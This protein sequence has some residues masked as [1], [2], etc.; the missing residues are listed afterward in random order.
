MTLIPKEVALELVKWNPGSP[1][2][3]DQ[4]IS[5]SM[6]DEEIPDDIVYGAIEELIHSFPDAK[7]AARNLSRLVGKEE[8]FFPECTTT[9]GTPDVAGAP[10]TTIKRGYGR[11]RRDEYVGEEIKAVADRVGENYW[12]EAD[13]EAIADTIDEASIINAVQMTVVGIKFDDEIQRNAAYE[14]LYHNMRAFDGISLEKHGTLI[15]IMHSGYDPE[16]TKTA[17]KGLLNDVVRLESIEIGSYMESYNDNYTRPNQQERRTSGMAD[18]T[19]PPGTMDDIKRNDEDLITEKPPVKKPGEPFQDNDYDLAVKS[20]V[21]QDQAHQLRVM[22]LKN[23]ARELGIKSQAELH[24]L[25]K[26]LYKEPQQTGP[27]K[28]LEPQKTE[29][30]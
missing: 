13:P 22:K 23:Q 5:M 6:D 11:P 29:L 15:L 12:N 16:T 20:V 21:G 14:K 26:K 8:H 28:P 30:A 2:P 24:D 27:Q 4:L 7:Q 10:P 1:S 17:I 19:I 25:A 18:E 3:I 9:A